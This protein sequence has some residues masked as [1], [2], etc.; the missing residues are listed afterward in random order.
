LYTIKETAMIKKIVTIITIIS[1]SLY[2]VFENP[3][4]GIDSIGNGGLRSAYV[5]ISAVNVNPAITPFLENGEVGVHSSLEDLDAAEGFGWGLLAYGGLPITDKLAAQVGL[6]YF[7]VGGLTYPSSEGAIYY[8]AKINAGVSYKIL[9]MLSIGL[10]GIF[11]FWNVD[12]AEDSGTRRNV[13]L[14]AGIYAHKLMDVLSVGITGENLLGGDSA[15]EGSGYQEK[16]PVRLTG[17]FTLNF[18]KTAL[19]LYAGSVGG[20]FS[21]LNKIINV[22]VGVL[23]TDSFKS[24][25]PSL[26]AGVK[27]SVF[28]IKYAFSYPLAFAGT[29]GRHYLGVQMAIGGTTSAPSADKHSRPA[30]SRQPEARQPKTLDEVDEAENKYPVS[31]DATH[32]KYSSFLDFQTKA[33]TLFKEKNYLGAIK[34]TIKILSLSPYNATG[35]KY[36]KVLYPK[37]TPEQQGKVKGALSSVIKKLKKEGDKLKADGYKEVLDMIDSM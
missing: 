34:N 6:D 26:G 18:D 23:L 15:T 10:M 28:N 1:A 16:L 36:M 31:F 25:T 4:L 11:Q 14:G 9:D 35:R 12:E 7:S 30:V 27:L 17:G 2:C 5:S 3:I 24:V 22:N 13:N 29:A 19:P 8:E 21:L 37:L 32:E 20:G 33:R